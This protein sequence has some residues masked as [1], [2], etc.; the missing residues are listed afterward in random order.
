VGA[1]E[2]R[3]DIP[4][5]TDG[6]IVYTQDIKLPGMLIAVVAH[7]PRFGARVRSFDDTDARSL[8]GVADV[9]EVP[10]GVAVVARDYWTATRARDLIS[11]DWD[12]SEAI[13]FSSG[14]LFDEY[15]QI[16]D[17][18]GT[19]ARDDGRIDDALNDAGKIVEAEYEFPYLCHSAM[20]PLNCVVQISEGGCEIW[21]AAQQQTRDQADA[22]AILGIE[23]A[24]VKI[25][26]LYA[27]GA[28]GRRACKDYTVE[29]VQ[30][31]KGLGT[32]VPV[33][34]VWTREDDMQ[35]GQFRP[36]NF[37]RL[38]AGIDD[39][40]KLIAWHHRLVG[41]S[42]NGQESPAWVEN[43]VD[44]T[45]VHGAHDWTYDVPNIRVETHSPEKDVPVLWYRGTGA[46]HT[47]FAVETFIDE[48]AHAAQRDPIEY[49]LDLLD[50]NPRLRNVLHLAA[51]AFDRDYVD[52]AGYGRGIAICQQR[53]TC[54]AQVAEV[55]AHDNG[56]FSVERVVAAVDCGLVINPDILRAQIEGGTGFGLSSTIAEEITI[57]NGYVEQ[58]N[59]DRYGLLRINQ[60][61]SVDV[62]I[63]SSDAPPSGIGDVSPMVTSAAVANALFD[64][65]GIR[66]RRLPIRPSG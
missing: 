61:P 36:L 29:A 4:V 17:V 52:R 23:P 41:Q 50:A 63:V 24:Q 44:S 38:R 13:R 2:P 19:I 30:V 39:N 20:E 64:A 3:L 6:S 60:M 54:Y 12:E 55:A 62:H 18:K 21:N 27:G 1:Y 57:K 35:S 32:G 53:D 45:S 42:I 34:L 59:F 5:K 56:N 8:T 37:H 25:N 26:M 66:H 15:R 40:G 31:A 7:A 48:V 33:K 10:S 28:F 14:D 47:V 43:G 11:I 58:S 16:A 49:R 51:A 65:T 46:T 22:A 9:F